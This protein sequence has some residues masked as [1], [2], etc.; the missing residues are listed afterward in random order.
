MSVTWHSGGLGP[1][2]HGHP[3][4]HSV[5][6]VAAGISFPPISLSVVHLCLVSGSMSFKVLYL[7]RAERPR[8]ELLGAC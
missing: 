3:W 8:V 4:L 7:H 2:A 1:E 5:G 6:T